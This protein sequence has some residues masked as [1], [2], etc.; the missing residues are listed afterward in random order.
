MSAPAGRSRF[1]SNKSVKNYKVHKV[2]LDVKSRQTDESYDLQ[3]GQ[4]YQ[5]RG[6]IHSMISLK[7]P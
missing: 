2:K 4:D 1:V 5:A 6:S 7:R 3:E